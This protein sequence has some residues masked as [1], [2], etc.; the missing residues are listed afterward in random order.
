MNGGPLGQGYE[1]PMPSRIRVQ[2]RSQ[3]SAP[4]G[5]SW[6]VRNRFRCSPA[7]SRCSKR[8]SHSRPTATTAS[9][10]AIAAATRHFPIPERRIAR[11]HPAASRRFRL[12]LAWRRRPDFA[13]GTSRSIQGAELEGIRHPFSRRGTRDALVLRDEGSTVSSARSA[14]DRSKAKPDEVVQTPV[15]RLSGRA[16][17]RATNADAVRA[18]EVVLTY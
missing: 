11:P 12:N 2:R 8:S 7:R 17:S 9:N 4:P 3:Y 10:A 18:S 5:T 16:A 1:A 13:P 6:I 14:H 15:A